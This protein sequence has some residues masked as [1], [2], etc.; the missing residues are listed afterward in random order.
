M[1][2]L[3]F[4]FKVFLS[5]AAGPVAVAVG[6][7]M[8]S[9]TAM[10]SEAVVSERR[11]HYMM[12]AL[13]VAMVRSAVMAS[14]TTILEI[15]GIHYKLA[16]VWIARYLVKPRYR[17]EYYETTCCSGMSFIE[18]FPGGPCVSP[19]GLLLPLAILL[20]LLVAYI[21][22]HGALAALASKLLIDEGTLCLFMPTSFCCVL[23][24]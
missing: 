2:S 16:R 21:V 5:A 9:P 17:S 18:C 20:P 3:F 24:P 1:Y 12:V 7:H 14:I 10:A 22:L 8:V 11:R 13:W 19:L 6:L 15:S 4:S 23:P